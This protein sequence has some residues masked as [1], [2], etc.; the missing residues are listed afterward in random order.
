MRLILDLEEISNPNPQNKNQETIETSDS[1]ASISKEEV[2]QVIEKLGSLGQKKLDLEKRVNIVEKELGER[3]EYINKSFIS[4]SNF[5]KTLEDNQEEVKTITKHLFFFVEGIFTRLIELE[6]L[7]QKFITEQTKPNNKQILE[8]SGE[9]T[10]EITPS[11]V[12]GATLKQVGKLNEDFQTLEQQASNTDQEVEALKR[13]VGSLLLKQEEFEANKVKLE[14]EIRL[15][16]RKNASLIDKFSA[17]KT[18]TIVSISG[19]FLFL[20]VIIIVLFIK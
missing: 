1:L 18:A 12:Y 15:L 20:V 14:D 3:W 11:Q 9:I 10:Q 13:Q 17:I 7:T 2:V 4:F 6:T 19:L 8:N 16:I 5:Q